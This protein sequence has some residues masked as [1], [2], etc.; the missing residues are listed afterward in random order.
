MKV[1]TI[2]SFAVPHIGHAA[3]LRACERF[4]EVTVG[5]NSDAF[6]QSYKG[7]EAP[8]RQAERMELIR[9]L[10]YTVKL[11]DG[12]GFELI[13][14]VDPDVIAVGTD[15]ARRDYLHQIGVTQDELDRWGISVVYIPM[16]PLGI[17]STEVVRRCQSISTPPSPTSPPTSSPSTTP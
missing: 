13:C 9:C 12:P 6:I 17:S 11:N 7:T 5:V 8:F 10:G 2:G 3:F 15:W 14:E 1:L 4:G 16:R